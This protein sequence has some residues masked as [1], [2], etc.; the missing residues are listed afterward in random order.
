MCSQ[1]QHIMTFQAHQAYFLVFTDF[2]VDQVLDVG[3]VAYCE[4]SCNRMLI[5]SH[6][7]SNFA[8]TLQAACCIIAG[9]SLEFSIV[10]Q[11]TPGAEYASAWLATESLP[12]KHTCSDRHSNALSLTIDNMSGSICRRF[13][14]ALWTVQ[15][16]PRNKVAYMCLSKRPTSVPWFF[17]PHCQPT[18]P[19]A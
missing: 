17:F 11:P 14:T 10:L 18:Q 16:E 9:W 13:K 8:C 7:N 3:F 6:A 5:L 12:S 1:L 19:Q 4:S 2:L 15:A